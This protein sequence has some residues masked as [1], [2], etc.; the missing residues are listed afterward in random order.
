MLPQLK[1]FLVYLFVPIVLWAIHT[2]GL[3]TFAIPAVVFG[4]IPLLELF[5]P[6]DRSRSWEAGPGL[7]D[8]PA[9]R[10]ALYLAVPSQILILAFYLHRLSQHDYA[11]WELIGLTGT[12]GLC[13][14]VFGINVAHELGHRFRPLEQLLSRVLF[15]T[16]LYVH[17][18]IHHNRGH[19]AFFGTPQD[20]NT[21]RAGESVYRFWLRSIAGSY[22][23]SWRL[24]LKTLRVRRQAFFGFSNEMLYWQ[25]IQLTVLVAVWFFFGTWP[26]LGFLAA[27]GVGVMLLETVNY[28]EHYGLM[29]RCLPDG[30]FET[31]ASHLAWNSDHP[32]GRTLLFEVTRH[33][34][35]HLHSSRPYQQLSRLESSPQMPT[36]YPGTILLA[37]VPAAWFKVMDPRVM[38]FQQRR[39]AQP[40][41]V[42][43][44]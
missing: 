30:G 39:E 7:Q 29:R 36:G 5:L 19:H 40:R 20:P 25:T 32:L 9:F 31:M 23:S 21:A 28:I 44:P 17:V 16:G 11:W 34:D 43:T 6:E 35:H 42:S 41:L 18:I 33:S 1:Y 12:V 14:G 8:R 24:G 3:W 27:A 38:Q 15:L 10:W 2:G 13:C 22:V 4:L 26:L 37:L